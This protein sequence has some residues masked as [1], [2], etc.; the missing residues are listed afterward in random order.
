[1]SGTAGMAGVMSLLRGSKNVA[2]ESW[3]RT[4]LDTV[5]P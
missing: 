2:G 3:Y 5:E 1:M 4:C